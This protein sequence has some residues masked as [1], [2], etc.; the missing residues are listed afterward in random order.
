MKSYLTS[1]CVAEEKPDEAYATSFASERKIPYTKRYRTPFLSVDTISYANRE[2][3]LAVEIEFVAMLVRLSIDIADAM[4]TRRDWR[5]SVRWLLICV[6]LG[7]VRSLIA[8]VREPG[9]HLVAL[10]M[11]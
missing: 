3:L 6:P 4:C 2:A 8:G 10:L 5:W 7:G 11:R 1:F 9:W